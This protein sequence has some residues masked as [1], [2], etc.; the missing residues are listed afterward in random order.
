M[1]SHLEKVLY[2]DEN[3]GA[4]QVAVDPNNPN[5]VYADLGLRDRPVE[6]GQWQGPEA[7]FIN[8]RMEVQVGR[9]SR[10]DYPL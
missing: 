6:N 1:G 4:V 10:K 2:K 8:R 3:T 7:G 9:S 5:I